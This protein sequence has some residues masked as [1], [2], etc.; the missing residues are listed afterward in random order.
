MKQKTCSRHQYRPAASYSE[1]RPDGVSVRRCES[2]RTSAKELE[3][4]ALRFLFDD[5]VPDVRVRVPVCRLRPSVH[6]IGRGCRAEPGAIREASLLEYVL[7][8]SVGGRTR[9]GSF[10]RRVFRYDM[11]EGFIGSFPW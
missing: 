6:V 5:P 11:L 3:C 10:G 2:S 9:P 4:T 7:G 8:G 1:R